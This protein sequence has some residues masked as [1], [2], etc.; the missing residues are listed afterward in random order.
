MFLVAALAVLAT[1][2]GTRFITQDF[3]TEDFRQ[4]VV[5]RCGDEHKLSYL[6]HCQACASIWVAALVATLV[7]WHGTPAWTWPLQVAAYSELTVLLARS[8]A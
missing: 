8:E 4:W 7:C 5:R 3:L 1:S 6:V 2:R